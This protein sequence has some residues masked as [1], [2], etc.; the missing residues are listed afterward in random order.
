MKEGTRDLTLE[1]IRCE[2]IMDG[3]D[4]RARLF[5]LGAGQRIPWHYHSQIADVFFCLEGAIVVETRAPQAEHLLRPG[6][7]CR[8]PPMTA[9][10]VHGRDDGP[11]RYLLLQGVG[12]YDNHAV[13][14]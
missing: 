10:C 13:G 3:A 8:V 14:G 7:S 2:T 9:H 12:A 6:E 11:C 5:A 4:M 1:E